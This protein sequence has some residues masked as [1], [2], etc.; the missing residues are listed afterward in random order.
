MIIKKGRKN[1]VFIILITLL[2]LTTYVLYKSIKKN[3]LDHRLKQLVKQK[4]HQLYTI[5]YD[6]ISVDEAG[7]DLYIRNIWVRGDTAQQ[8]KMLQKRDT[9][10]VSVLFDIH[11]PV[12]KIVDFK[13]ARALL[14]K[15]LECK[16]II[17]SAPTIQI[18]IYPGQN[19]QKDSRKQG[20][21]LYKQILGRFKLIKA[22]SI[23]V[24]K[25]QVVATNYFTKELKFK[26]DNTT[27]NLIEPAIDSTYNQDTSRTLFC[28]KISIRS[29]KIWLGNRNNT[30]EIL[31]ATFDT[32]SKLVAFSSLGYDASKADGSFKSIIKGVK[33]TGIEWVGPVENSTLRID[34]MVVGKGEIEASL[35]GGK[36]TEKRD[37]HILTGWIEKFSIN[38]I[39]VNSF[40]FINFGEKGKGEQISV[41]ENVVSI[42]N[43][44]LTRASK[45]DETLVGQ[46]EEIAV[47]NE[48]ITIE[49]SDRFYK[50]RISGIS[51]STKNKKL[52]IRSVMI[53]PKMN[54][55][56][57][58]SRAKY[59]KDRFDVQLRNITCTGINIQKLVKGE[60]ETKNIRM[61]GSSIKVFRDLS[62]P[63]DTISKNGHQTSYPH[64]IIHYLG[65]KMKVNRLISTDTYIEYKEKNASSKESGKVT[66]SH[67]DLITDNISTAKASVREKMTLS[68][69]SRFLNRIPI[70]GRFT[71]LLDNWH[72][73]RFTVEASIPDRV[74]ATVLNQILEPMAL[75]KVEKGIIN[76]LYFTMKADTNSSF[77][78]VIMPYHDLKISLLKKK[79]DEY[80]KKGITSVLANIVVRNKNEVGTEMRTANVTVKKNKYRSFFNFIWTT[81]LK[82]LKDVTLQNI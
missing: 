69:K 53:I 31:D 73:G 34:K 81:L 57:F 1:A 40:H 9:N 17:V 71:F 7:G 12:L 29:D 14:S 16:E 24:I 32:D 63:I 36:E 61:N 35:Q 62:Y 51:L 20:E 64:Q 77:G 56:T 37:P 28:R 13:T 43:L 66:F 82:G 55:P 2:A 52:G 21:E 74:D 78:K 60:I 68:F 42:K 5:D 10:A 44:N 11:I 25:S 59:Q 67:S 6:S 22:D 49:T 26:T 70:E 76:S 18:Y 75:L 27:I 3:F 38:N 39:N 50:Y 45:F 41:K 4:T 72:K 15:Q 8:M 47:K 65:L 54:E 19:K 58:S 30:A 80:D 23:S 48:A 79:G 33:L 46:A